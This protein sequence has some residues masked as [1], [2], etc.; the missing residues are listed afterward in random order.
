MIVL[1]ATTDNVQAVLSAAKATADLACYSS[2]R[3]INTTDY[4]PGRTQTQT[5]DT[6]DVNIVPSPGAGDQRVVDYISIFNSDTA[7]ATVTV[8]F[9]ASGTERVLWKGTLAVGEKVEYVEGLGWRNFDNTGTVK[10]VGATGAAGT[11]GGGTILGTGTSTVAMG[12]FPGTSHATLVVTGQAAV[13]GGS[14]VQCWVAPV[15]TSDHSAD[16][17]IVEPLMAYA[18]NVVAGTGFTLHLVNTSTLFSPSEP[19]HNR[20]SRTFGA[21]AD[22]GPGQQDRSRASMTGKASPSASYGDWSVSWLYTQ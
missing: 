19:R 13:V 7:S 6:T 3:D 16:E 14:L 11:N 5:N 21:G 2:Y 18:S 17:H 20:L 15:A 10:G 9:D 8:K 1:N 12:S 22:V 4:T